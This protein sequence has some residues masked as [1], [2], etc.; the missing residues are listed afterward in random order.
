[1]T[2]VKSS[3]GLI[4]LQVQCRDTTHRYINGKN[5]KNRNDIGGSKDTVSTVQGQLPNNDEGSAKK[6]LSGTKKEKGTEQG[7]KRPRGNNDRRIEDGNDKGTPRP[8]PSNDV[9]GNDNAEL[10]NGKLS[11][12]VLKEGKYCKCYRANY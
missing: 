5:F 2:M 9:A 4:K 7:A 10:H 11:S 3:S 8:E 6:I 1:M 12:Y